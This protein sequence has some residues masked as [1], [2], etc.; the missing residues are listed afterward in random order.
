MGEKRKEIDFVITWVDGADPEWK[1]VKQ[2]FL[3]AG[4][5]DDRDERYRDWDLLRYWFRGVCACAPWVRKIFFVTFGHI[6]QWLVT[7]HPK[8]TVIRHEDFIPPE[9]LPTF[10]SHTIEWNLHRIPGLSE[11]FVYFNDDM[12]LLGKVKPRDFFRDGRPRDLLA[13]QPVVANAENDV[14]PY[15]YLN[16]SMALAKH[17]QKRETMKLHPG[18]YFH[19]GYPPL[20]FFYNLLELA[21]PKF[22]GF[23]TVHGPSPFLKETFCTLWKQE[24]E[25]LSD[26]CSHRFRSRGDVSQYLAR[27]WQKLSGAFSPCNARKMCRYYELGTRNEALYRA[28]SRRNG[29]MVCINDA[30]VRI[31]FEQIKEEL[32][33]AFE[34]AFPVPSS[35]E[36][37]GRG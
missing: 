10:N 4:Q 24:K 17:F 1:R 12:F 25:L 15:I 14:M 32:S 8:L 5:Q 6:P 33:D 35:F 31:C 21:F 22:T 26:T 2:G 3:P 11:Q 19:P 34:T 7:D 23:Y 9:Y 36:K 30:N 37:E 28:V 20:Y 27:E 16:N 13:L 29:P 18:N